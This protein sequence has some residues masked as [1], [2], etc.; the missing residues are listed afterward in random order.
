MNHFHYVG[1]YSKKVIADNYPKVRLF[2]PQKQNECDE[3]VKLIKH[4]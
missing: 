1:S 4:G 2:K 3:V